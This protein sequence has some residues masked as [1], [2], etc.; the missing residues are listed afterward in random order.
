MSG[1]VVVGVDGSESARNA[2]REAID[3]AQARESSVLAL[4][5]VVIPAMSGYE[6]TPIDLDSMKADAQKM[7]DQEVAYVVA[8]F[9]TPPTV[10]IE[11]KTVTGHIGIEMLRAAKA[12]GG[13]DL[14]VAGS[15]GLGGF[16]SLLLGSVTTYLAHHL[17]CPLLIIPSVDDESVDSEPTTA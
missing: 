13:A 6:Y 8:T 1:F 4:H 9:A 16:R 3:Q 2:L 17:T 15:R 5:V 10:A 12:D 7:I 14:V 11:A